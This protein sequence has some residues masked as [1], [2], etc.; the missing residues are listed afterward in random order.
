[1]LNWSKASIRMK[2]KKNKQKWNIDFVQ[3]NS[4]LGERN[5]YKNVNVWEFIWFD[6]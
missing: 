3:I 6:T 5:I 1:M 4:R 2:K